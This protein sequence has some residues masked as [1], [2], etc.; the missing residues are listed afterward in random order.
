MRFKKPGGKGQPRIASTTHAGTGYDNWYFVDVEADPP[1][2]GNIG[3][4]CGPTVL[5]RTFGEWLEIELLREVASRMRPIG[6]PT[7]P[8]W[9][10]TFRSVPEF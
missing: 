8:D 6:S 2:V 9:F 5:Y 1:L 7:Q 10:K 3:D 4:G